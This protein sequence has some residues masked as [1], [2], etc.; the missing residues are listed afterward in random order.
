MLSSW[1][2]TH[3]LSLVFELGIHKPTIF[4]IM[5]MVTLIFELSSQ[6]CSRRYIRVGYSYTH[7]PIVFELSQLCSIFL[8]YTKLGLPTF[9][10]ATIDLIRVGYSYLLFLIGCSF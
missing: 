4:N 6:L 7:T 3:Q 5:A 1:I 10:L 9:F 8:R 2:S